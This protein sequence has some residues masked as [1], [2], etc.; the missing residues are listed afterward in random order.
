MATTTR[1]NE[2]GLGLGL[3]LRG[4]RLRLRCGQVIGTTPG[5]SQPGHLILR[6]RTR[7]T[8]LEETGMA[9]KSCPMGGTQ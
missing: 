6:L 2:F 3:R 7:T 1:D 5:T 8:T 4:P 9:G